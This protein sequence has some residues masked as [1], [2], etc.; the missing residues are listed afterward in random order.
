MTDELKAKLAGRTVVASVSGGKDS[1]ALSL[2]LTEQGIEHQRIFC[3]T[4]WE[5]KATYEYLRGPLA[6]K[7]G[8]IVWLDPPLKMVPLI[9]SRGTFPKGHQRFCT[10]QLKV[11]P[12]QRYLR[13]LQDAGE[14]VINAVGI[15]AAESESRSKMLEWEWQD[16]F[17]CEVWRPLIRWTEQDVID[18]HTRHGLRPNPLYLK[19]A[20]RVGCWPCIYA[21][22]EDI[23]M[24]ADTDPERIE[25]IRALEA[26]VTQAAAERFA[27]RGEE[28]PVLSWFKA[29][30]SLGGSW[31]IDK[32]VEWSRTSRGGRQFELFAAAPHEQGCVRWGLCE[33]PGQKRTDNED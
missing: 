7:I 27:A 14:E 2:W 16:G 11:F 13:G 28:A 4:G 23:R 24:L 1:A 32:A 5:H 33:T 31:P 12:V 20:N 21:R 6:E 15:R 9:I 29:K 25:E 3:D 17:D 22:K 8:P 30:D 18:I 19:G 10:Q 26:Q